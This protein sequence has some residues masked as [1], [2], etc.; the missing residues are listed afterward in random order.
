[1]HQPVD[2]ILSDQDLERWTQIWRSN[3]CLQELALADFLRW[4]EAALQALV[5]GPQP[6]PLPAQI[7]PSGLARVALAVLD[8]LEAQLTAA[9]EAYTGYLVRMRNGAY[10][11]P[12]HHHRYPVS[13]PH[14]REAV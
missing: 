9:L 2:T 7:A 14:F 8:D 4:P 3:Q 13:R 10:V 5:W 11:E 12:L 1:M 6:A